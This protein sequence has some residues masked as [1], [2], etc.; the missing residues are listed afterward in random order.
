MR[1]LKAILNF[2]IATE[3]DENE[4]SLLRLWKGES[5]R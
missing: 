1:F 2:K 4:Y 3:G 5:G